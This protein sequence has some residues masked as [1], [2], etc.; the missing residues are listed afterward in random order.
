[1]ADDA[2]PPE[3]GGE[4]AAQKLEVPELEVPGLQI[5]AEPLSA[6]GFAPFG[7]V[8]EAGVAVNDR[9]DSA[10]AYT[11]NAGSATRWDDV[12]RIEVAE[13]G[14]RLRV[15]VARAAPRALP[16]LVDFLERHP[17]G[18]QAFVPMTGTRFLVVVAPGEG[19]PRAAD[20]RAFVAGPGQGINYRRGLWHF[21]L[22]A[23]ERVSDFL[24]LDRDG[25]GENLEILSLDRPLRVRVAS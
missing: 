14:G 21:P 12:A 16:A 9:A 6:A 18:S 24:V 22:S 15:S 20:V 23:L 3:S 2:P 10:P 19:P 11:I 8:I 25:P 7:D 4:P 13:G 5:M 1:M 17:L